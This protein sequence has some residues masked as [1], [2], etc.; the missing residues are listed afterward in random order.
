MQINQQ[1]GS[2]LGSSLVLILLDSYREY[3]E[4]N[5]AQIISVGYMVITFINLSQTI[6]TK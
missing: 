6:S 2:K 4:K 5:L 1:V 3:S